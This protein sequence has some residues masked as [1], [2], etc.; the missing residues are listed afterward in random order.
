[1]P[2][3]KK[4]LIL[5]ATAGS[6]HK[7]AAQAL[8]QEIE[9]QGQKAEIIDIVDY[10][11]PLARF[12]YSQGY[13]F[14]ITRLP[15]LWGILYFLSETPWLAPINVKLRR[16]VNARLLKPLLAKL[17]KEDPEIIISTQFLASEIVSYAK[18]KNGLRSKLVTV[19]TD[20]GVHHFWIAPSTD[21]YCCA[22]PMT[23]E[24]LLKKGIP[25][26]NISV[27][28][29]PLHQ[30]FNLDLDKSALE[31]EFHFKKDDLTI[32]IATGGTG[33]G[34]IETIVDL[35]KPLAKILVVCGHNKALYQRLENRKDPRIKVF[36]FVDFMHKLMKI[37]D[38]M[39]TKAGGLTLTEALASGLPMIFFFLIPGQE[40]INANTLIKSGAAQLGRTPEQILQIVAHLKKN[41][42]LL[43][44]YS[45]RSLQLAH[46][47]AC[48]RII[49]TLGLNLS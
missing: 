2:H 23:K 31:K 42:D 41:P 21:R 36:G 25:E 17:V 44:S 15:T 28:G 46:K 7:K 14:L 45:S 38:L 30:M 12:L 43:Q 29:I 35:L 4:I 18:I 47:D 11:N 22:S 24:I 3:S 48:Q 26:E 27:T 33:A 34:P 5:Y 49:S 32:L 20:F 9:S 37:S 39:I 16:F 8:H 10:L 19:I 40:S 1:M 6:G 13:L